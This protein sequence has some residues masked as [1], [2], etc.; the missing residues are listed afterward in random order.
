MSKAFKGTNF[1]YG[2]ILD[3][4]GTGGQADDRFMPG[5]RDEITYAPIAAATIP[6]IFWIAPAPCRIISVTERH[7]TVAG[8]AGTMQ[9]EKVPSGTAIGSGTVILAT[10][11]DLTSTANTN[12][13]VL[14][15]TS[16]A[17]N[18]ATGAAVLSKG[19]ALAGKVASGAATSYAN[20]VMSLVVEWL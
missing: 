11:L 18:A 19:D 6:V 9:V 20:G 12:V 16:G 10:A 4:D 8:Q 1:K 2:V 13:T 17:P 14:G 7:V 3:I 15:L 5:A